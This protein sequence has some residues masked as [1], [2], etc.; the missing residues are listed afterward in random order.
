MAEH[1]QK[2]WDMLSSQRSSAHNF[3]YIPHF[4]KKICTIKTVAPETAT[5]SPPTDSMGTTSRVHV[6][7]N[8]STKATQVKQSRQITEP[9][10]PQIKWN[11]DSIELNGTL[12]H[13]TEGAV[14]TG[15]TPIKVSPNDTHPYI[16]LNHEPK[17]L[18]PTS[19][20]VVAHFYMWEG[21]GPLPNLHL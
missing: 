13:L 17:N 20:Q 12:P 16:E 2:Q 14:Q 10:V 8:E 6:H 9:V 1:R 5:S 7:K 18:N 19:Y 11:T 4:F 15:S 21:R 3:H